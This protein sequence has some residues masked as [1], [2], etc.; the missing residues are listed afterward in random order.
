[1]S[2]KINIPRAVHDALGFTAGHF[3]TVLRLSWFP[4]TFVFVVLT[5]MIGPLGEAYEGGDQGRSNMIWLLM[6]NGLT[7]LMQASIFV[8]LVGTVVRGAPPHNRSLHFAFGVREVLFVLAAVASVV[9][10]IATT[11]APAQFALQFSEAFALEREAEQAFFFT[12]GSL[13]EGSKNYLFDGPHPIRQAQP[14][15]YWG[16]QLLAVYVGLRILLLPFAIAGGADRPIARALRISSGLNI[17]RMLV[18]AVIIFLL[19]V[20]T[21]FA[22]GLIA[23]RAFDSIMLFQMM[24][25]VF[26]TWGVDFA[27]PAWANALPRFAAM[28][29]GGVFVVVLQS[30]SMGLLSGFAGAL[31]LQTERE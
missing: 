13:H 22:A 23:D 19:Q 7:L 24:L 18:I 25:N 16:G 11:L 9:F 10:L 2:A 30:F 31:I 17:F 6:T 29:L 15:I 27:T 28:T 26:Y 12:E 21:N 4:L 14:Y 3:G 20:L 8:A 5:L 1:M